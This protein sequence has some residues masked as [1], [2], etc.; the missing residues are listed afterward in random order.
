MKT[1]INVSGWALLVVST[2]LGIWFAGAGDYKKSERAAA[3]F[4]FANFLLLISEPIP[5]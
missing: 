3:V 5:S 4:I 2:C 1:A